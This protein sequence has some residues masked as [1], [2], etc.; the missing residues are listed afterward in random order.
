MYKVAWYRDLDNISPMH[1][2]PMFG[3]QHATMKHLHKNINIMNGKEVS[4]PEKLF[5]ESHIDFGVYALITGL[6]IYCAFILI[7]VGYLLLHQS[8]IAE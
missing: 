2:V 4:T 1:L 5:E 6:G 8:S 7:Q 3:H